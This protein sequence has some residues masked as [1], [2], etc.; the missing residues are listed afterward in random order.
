MYVP[1]V[2]VTPAYS[3]P[4]SFSSSPVPY[5]VVFRRW[6]KCLAILLSRSS[7][8]RRQCFCV[9]DLRGAEMTIMCGAADAQLPDVVI[10]SVFYRRVVGHRARAKWSSER[11]RIQVACP[12]LSPGGLLLTHV[13]IA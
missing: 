12:T 4:M 10:M 3:A 5:A 2:V 9:H 1:G 11:P 8:F 6:Q 7:G 13:P